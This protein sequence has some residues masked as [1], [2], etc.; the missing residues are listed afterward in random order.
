MTKIQ[1]DSDIVTIDPVHLCHKLSGKL[2]IAVWGVMQIGTSI[3]HGD[4]H[5]WEFIR[6]LLQYGRFH[7]HPDPPFRPQG[8]LEGEGENSGAEA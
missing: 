6:R 2:C 7:L 5:H 1:V 8:V 4:D 3:L